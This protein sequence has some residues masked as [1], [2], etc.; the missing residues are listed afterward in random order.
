ML[1]A[2]PPSIALPGYL[3]ALPWEAREAIADH[4]E[5]STLC[6]GLVARGCTGPSADPL[7]LDEVQDIL[8]TASARLEAA[9]A[10]L[11][12]ASTALEP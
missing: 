10:G 5:I 9:R 7:T 4:L 3:A 2:E 1:L 12:P 11:C 8:V 6:V